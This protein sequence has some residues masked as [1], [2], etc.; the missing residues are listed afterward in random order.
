[1]Y[2]ITSVTINNPK[3]IAH[4]NGILIKMYVLV[5]VRNLK[6]KTANNQAVTIFEGSWI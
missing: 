6:L 5:G 3:K 2:N 1:M 4:E